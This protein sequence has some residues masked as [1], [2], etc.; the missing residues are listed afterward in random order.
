MKNLAPVILFV[1]NRVEHTRQVVEALLENNLAKESVLYIYSDGPDLG[2]EDAVRKVR[3][4]IRH[5]SGFREINI[6]ERKE[7][8]GIEKSEI[9]AITEILSSYPEVIILED[10]LVVAY[11]FLEYMNHALKKYSKEKKIF[12]ISGYSYL[13][14]KSKKLPDSMLLNMPS[15]W[16]WA[17]WRDRWT[18]FREIPEKSDV[19]KII[20]NR[21]SLR[22]YDVNGA[23]YKAWKN[24]LIN[25]YKTGQYTWDVSWRIAQ[26]QHDALVL[27]PNQT[28]VQNIGFDG[29]GTHGE[30]RENVITDWANMDTK[31]QFYPDKIE[32][33]PKIKKTVIWLMK[34]QHWI[35]SIQ[36]K[37]V[38]FKR[39]FQ[40]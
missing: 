30:I 11:N 12:Y 21:E 2:E 6:I 25:Q 18:Y 7:N 33:S 17:T 31:I 15:T 24:M 39:K 28:L 1:Y 27:I 40:S 13:K 23:Y 37:L 8:Y 36:H 9:S 10:D 35:E 5:I 34:K 14:E 26:F 29:S 19:E 16:G 4:Y 22:R 32:E 20:N 3:D 38:H